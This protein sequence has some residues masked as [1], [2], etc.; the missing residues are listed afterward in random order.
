MV[1]NE[2]ENKEIILSL[3]SFKGRSDLLIKI[4]KEKLIGW[5]VI[6]IFFIIKEIC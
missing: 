4:F 6:L 1:L 2:L 5:L 3:V